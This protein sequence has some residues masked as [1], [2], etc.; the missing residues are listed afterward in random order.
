MSIATDVR[1]YADLALEQGRTALIQAASLVTTAN[2][3]LVADA[4][5]PAYAALGVADLVAVTVTKRIEAL[6]SDAVANA[7]KAQEG[8]KA[9]LSKAQ[10]DAVTRV[11]ELRERIDAGIGNVKSIQTRP[12]VKLTTEVYLDT[13]KR[14]YGQLTARGEARAAELLNDSRLSRVIG[15]VGDDVAPLARSAFDSARNVAADVEPEAVVRSTPTRK[16]TAAKQTAA[17]STAAKSTAAKSTAAKSTAA[18]RAAA[19]TSPVKSTAAK[20]TTAKSTTRR[21]AKKI[22]AKTGNTA[23]NA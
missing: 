13:A 17:K 21:T 19:K 7:S 20:S 10:Q 4:P 8:G 11:S 22:P 12:L 2:K 23:H 14:L 1:N 9:L 15:D 5:K 3:R 6:P 16:S 18:K